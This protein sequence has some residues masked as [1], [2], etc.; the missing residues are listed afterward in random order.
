[1]WAWPIVS[2]A[3]LPWWAPVVAG[4]AVAL[5]FP[6]I[7]HLMLKPVTA[8]VGAE[9]VAWAMGKPTNAL[10]VLGLAFVG[11]IAQSALGGGKKKD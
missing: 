6:K 7:Y 2:A 10:L 5:V 9:L 4:I 11:T 1:V 8:L 3:A